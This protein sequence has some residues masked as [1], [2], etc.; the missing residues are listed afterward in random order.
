MTRSVSLDADFP[1]DDGEAAAVAR[2]NDIDAA[3]FLCDES[4]HL[5]L[6]YASLADTRL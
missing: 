4:T 6:L 1:P 2:A 5:G 3:W